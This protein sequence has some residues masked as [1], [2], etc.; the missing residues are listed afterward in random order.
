[1]TKKPTMASWAGGGVHM[2]WPSWFTPRRQRPDLAVVFYT[3]AGCH[4]CEDAWRALAAWQRRYDFRLQQR[5]VDAD[6]ALA[7]RFG[8]W[9]PVIEVDGRVRLRGHFNPV[10][11]RRLLD[12]PVQQA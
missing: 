9:V 12:A 5:D 6:E 11:F 1:M 2:G 4:L 7:S 10:L 8:T 3:R